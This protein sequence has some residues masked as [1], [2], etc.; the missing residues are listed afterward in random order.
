MNELGK[1][2]L[3]AVLKS[4]VLLGNI[5]LTVI[6]SPLASRFHRKPRIPA[7]AVSTPNLADQE[8]K[9]AARGD[10]DY[11]AAFLFCHLKAAALVQLKC[12]L[13]DRYD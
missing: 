4:F 11:S 6:P 13:L 10:I 8:G 5:A 7:L 9:K 12:P 2:L 3:S 1:S